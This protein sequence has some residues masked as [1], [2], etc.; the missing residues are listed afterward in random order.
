MTTYEAVGR[1]L[2]AAGQRS[3]TRRAKSA[4]WPQLVWSL[5]TLLACLGL[6]SYA[7]WL[8]YEPA[9]YAVAGVSCAVLRW[10]VDWR[11][12]ES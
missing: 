6:L 7:A 8:I 3:K 12:D 1:F 4:Q 5:V 10:A 11:R 9:G 2:I